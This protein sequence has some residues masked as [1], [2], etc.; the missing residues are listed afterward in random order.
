[1]ELFCGIDVGT[2]SS[3]FC[4]LDR[5]QKVVK[6]WSGLTA[7]IC[8][9]LSKVPGKKKCI[10]EAGPLAESLCLKVEAMGA[11][12]EIVDS[13]HTKALLQGKKKTNRIDAKVLAELVLLGWYKPIH[14]KSG[15]ARTKRTVLTGRAALVHTATRLKNTIRGLAK[16][17]G[18]VLPAG[19]NGEVFAE[20]VAEATKELPAE[21][22]HT[23]K[24]LVE[25]WL[26]AHE[27]QKADY[28]LLKR[29]AKKDVVATRL[30]TVPGV[31]PATALAVV[32]TIATHERFKDPK[33]VASYIGLAPRVYQSGAVKFNGHVTKQ[34][35]NLLRWLLV[36][37]ATTL[38]GRTKNTCALKEWGLRLAAKKGI[39]K[40]RV[41]V[42]RRL[43]EL[44]F[45]LWR[46]ERDFDV[47]IQAPLEVE[48]AD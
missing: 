46:T 29:M 6:A 20:S 2:R 17:S 31:G 38:L 42:A 24:A 27:K 14:R 30:M 25:V 44:L 8:E 28:S 22:Q 19:E 5:D 47:S 11:N 41:A 26:L 16:A 35:D 23:L 4:V 13:R 1:M 40:A 34:G 36:E 33:Q 32:G 43:S 21:I 45:T 10:V 12:I 48:T 18:V 39:S 7:R 3:S 9:E 15:E 37:S